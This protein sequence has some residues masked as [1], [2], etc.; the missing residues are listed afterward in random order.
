[1]PFH[2]IVGR[3]DA[4]LFLTG[5]FV[6]LRYTAS[7]QPI[8][9]D[10]M[11]HILLLLALY[12]A[13]P[14]CSAASESVTVPIEASVLLDYQK[15]VAGRDIAGITH[16]SGPGARRDVI[17]MVLVQQALL[18]GGSS[19]QFKFIA[20]D[21]SARSPR[22]LT[23]GD[24]LLTFDS[25]WRQATRQYANDI[26]IS[27]PVIRRGEYFAA[28]A[29]APD[30]QK[31]QNA[32]SAADF[33]QLTAVSSRVFVTDWQTLAAMHLK[34]L[35][36]EDDWHTMA[37]LV[38]KQWVDFMLVPL[39]D[40]HLIKNDAAGIHL[41]LVPGVKILLDDSRHFAVSKH[42]PLAGRTFAALQRGLREL[43]QRGVIQQAYQDCGFFR[44][45]TQHWQVINLTP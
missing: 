32:R 40:Q 35:R 22:L 6:L 44:A 20:T 9:I 14:W 5:N 28:V 36:E 8:L 33:K 41:T 31:V 27:E 4:G 23:R 42:H 15:F 43:K 25:V 2:E 38:S 11:R 30:N 34:G 45:D 12:C 18:L 21:A 7:H 17:E 13:W 39:S 16:Y 3:L 24:L 19:L 37:R 26:L 10:L 29:A 1:M